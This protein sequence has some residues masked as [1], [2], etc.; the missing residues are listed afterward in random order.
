MTI[1][2]RMGSAVE[3]N[4]FRRRAKEAFRRSSIR[5]CPGIDINIKPKNGVAVPYSEFFAAFEQLEKVAKL[6]PKASTGVD[7]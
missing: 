4:L 1:V 2:R 3:R 7:A 5:N 6:N